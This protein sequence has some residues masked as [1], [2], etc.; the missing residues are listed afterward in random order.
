MNRPLSFF[1]LHLFRDNVSLQTWHA[2][3]DEGE[4]G[5]RI[6]LLGIYI[7]PQVQADILARRKFGKF[8]FRSLLV[9]PART[10]Y[11]DEYG[12]SWIKCFHEFAQNVIVGRICQNLTSSHE[13]IL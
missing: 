4:K 12:I 9:Y 5:E 13:I 6:Q 3:N 10:R 7:I 11:Y 1:F 2:Q 8:V